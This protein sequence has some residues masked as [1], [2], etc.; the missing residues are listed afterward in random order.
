MCYS[1]FRDKKIVS[2]SSKLEL[3]SR[4]MLF[5]LRDGLLRRML[6]RK[7]KKRTLRLETELIEPDY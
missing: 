1:Y 5:P 4:L 2:E 3:H 7:K 6:K